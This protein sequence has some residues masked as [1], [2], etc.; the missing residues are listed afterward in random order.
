MVE[1]DLTE[2]TDCIVCFEKATDPYVCKECD[3]ILC[4][5]CK[6][7]LPNK[8]ECPACRGMK[9]LTSVTDIE[10]QN[11]KAKELLKRKTNAKK[12]PICTCENE[13]LA[14]KC[15]AC[16]TA[17]D[18]AFNAENGKRCPTCTFMNKKTVSNCEACGLA[19][20][21]PN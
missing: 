21:G 4:G 3:N 18:D 2:A 1:Y 10:A 5:N 12:C 14:E 7:G 20:P 8:D 13:M 16:N 9:T 11:A 6:R 19:F 15:V 17:F